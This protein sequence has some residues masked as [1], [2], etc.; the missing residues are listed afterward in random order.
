[1]AP[2]TDTLARP[3]VTPPPQPDS[4]TASH[5]P[6]SRLPATPPATALPLPHYR[7]L[8]S[9][10]KESMPSDFFGQHNMEYKIPKEIFSET[11]GKLMEKGGEWLNKT[12][13]SCSL[14]AALMA[15]VAFATST[16][17][18]GGVQ[19]KTGIPTLVDRP[20]FD[21]FAIS[22][23]IALCSSVTSLALF[24]SILTSR[25]QE[26]DFHRDLPR[27][28]IFGLT[29][30]FMSITSM[31]VSFCAGHFFVL[32]DKLKDAAL[33]VYAVISLPVTLFALAQFP[34]YFDLIRATFSKVPD[35]SY[36]ASLR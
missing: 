9:Y 28:M 22:S 26:Q 1:M 32:K 25:Y 7:L 16:T 30:L 17:V 15:T 29:S 14:V 18:P 5:P 34:L 4:P 23:L 27:K 20:A 21:V 24:L 13:E 31:L 12:S 3:L 35:R 6:V 2:S 36:K 33:P 11:H 10:I 8:A 19:E